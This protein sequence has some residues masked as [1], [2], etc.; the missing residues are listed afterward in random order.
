MRLTRILLVLVFLAVA[1]VYTV[2][3]MA[4]RFSTAD[5]PPTLTCGEGIL[6]IS[7]K[8]DES[9]LLSG[10]TATDAQDGDLTDQVLVSGISKLLPG[11]TAKVT[12]V[13]F[14]SD[15]NMATLTRTIR[16]TDYQLP[17]F[18][19]SEP[20]VY[21]V[22][23]EIELLDRLHARDVV[24][25]DITGSIRVSRTEY[26]DDPEVNTIDVQITNS[27]GD[28]AYLTIPAILYQDTEPRP[29]VSLSTYLVYLNK[30]VS[31]DAESYLM[32]VTFEDEP[33]KTDKVEITGQVDTNAP[34]TYMVFYRC[35]HGGTTGTAIL[36]VV[37]E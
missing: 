26:T 22:M 30:G 20:L 25:G 32:D 11:N 3:D 31:F 36:T 5:V 16:Y 14:D 8:E 12:C 23:D 29:L 2:Q 21:T 24:E 13:V 10:V 4:L 27:M 6:D 37:V 17:R 28:T 18:Y 1:A 9:A 34:G 15:D 19:L 33:L 7:V 35:T